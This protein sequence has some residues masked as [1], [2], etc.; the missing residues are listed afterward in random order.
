M[1]KEPHERQAAPALRELRRFG[2]F[3]STRRHHRAVVRHAEFQVAVAH[4]VVPASPDGDRQLR[5]GLDGAVLLGNDER[6]YLG[7]TST[8]P[9]W[10]P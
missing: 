10:T 5:G 2:H 8:W 9:S 1:G 4:P 6:F 7:E 3:R